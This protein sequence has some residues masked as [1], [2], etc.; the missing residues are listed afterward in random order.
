MTRQQFEAAL[1]K[2]PQ[3][4]T[5]GEAVFDFRAMPDAPCSEYRC[6]TVNTW[7]NCWLAMEE[8][9]RAYVGDWELDW[10]D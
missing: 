5:V 3:P 1:V 6:I 8:C 9:W 7:D 2:S 4:G 10:I